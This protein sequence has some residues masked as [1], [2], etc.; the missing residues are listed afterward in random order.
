MFQYLIIEGTLEE[1]YPTFWNQNLIEISPT[2]IN[3]ECFSIKKIEYDD[4]IF[5]KT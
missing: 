1:K 5:L 4:N 3:I 2:V